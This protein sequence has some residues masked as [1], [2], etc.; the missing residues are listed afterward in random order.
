[1]TE[2]QNE[3]QISQ[4]GRYAVMSDVNVGSVGYPRF[5]LCSTYCIYDVGAQTITIRRLPF[6]FNKYITEMLGNE[7]RLEDWLRPYLAAAQAE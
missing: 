1:M 7:Y 4:N 2:K 3:N 6:D 5:D